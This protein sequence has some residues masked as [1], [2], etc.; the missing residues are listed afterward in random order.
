MR[1][2]YDLTKDGENLQVGLLLQKGLS[3][4]SIMYYG[5]RRLKGITC[6]YGTCFK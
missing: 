3:D 5:V 4:F 2:A 1:L 6:R